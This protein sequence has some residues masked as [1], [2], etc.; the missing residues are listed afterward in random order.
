MRAKETDRENESEGEGEG[1]KLDK[2]STPRK[3]RGC[4]ADR[5]ANVLCDG[6]R[7]GARER[8]HK[9]C[10]TRNV[11]HRLQGEVLRL[12]SKFNVSLKFY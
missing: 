10:G 7:E 8:K 2:R 6:E 4:S 1:R 11:A 12:K 9:S 5:R 3:P